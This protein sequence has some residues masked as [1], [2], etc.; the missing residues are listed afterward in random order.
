MRKVS[1]YLL[2]IVIGSYLSACS[3][4]SSSVTEKEKAENDE[5]VRR[6]SRS[7]DEIATHFASSGKH[8]KQYYIDRQVQIMNQCYTAAD[9]ASC[10][11]KKLDALRYE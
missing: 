8:D 7:M 9:E 3:E 4:K 6:I 1:L 10:V 2:C 11:K 5:K